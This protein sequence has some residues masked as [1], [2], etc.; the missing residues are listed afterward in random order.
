VK[1]FSKLMLIALGFGILT[2]ALSL[3]PSKPVGAAGS[4]PVMVTNTPLPVQGTVGV[5]NFPTT[6]PISGT[7]SVG[8]FPTT[9][10][11]SFSNTSATPLHIRDVDN[12]AHNPF[13]IA[14]VCRLAV[15]SEGCEFGSITVPAGMEW[16]I[17]T[18][19]VVATLPSGQRGIVSVQSS[20]GGF[21]TGA[22]IPLTFA[23]NFNGSDTYEVTQALRLYADPN[24]SVQFVAIRNDATGSASFEF[25]ISGY[26]VTC[27]SGSGC[28]VP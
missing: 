25:E 21:A 12:P 5:N 19:S 11:V 7:V 4:A 15:G 24:S 20:V 14:Q 26:T 8:N 23:G 1:Q 3:V 9:Q 6:Q 16:V 18:V 2:L 13:G 10:N 22:N 27:G 28:P 17:E